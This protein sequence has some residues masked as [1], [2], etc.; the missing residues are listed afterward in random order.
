VIEYEDEFGRARTGRRSEVPAHLLPPAAR[1]G[2]AGD[3]DEPLVEYTDEFG[4]T[5]TVPRSEV[6]REFLRKTDE[7]VAE[8]EWAF[9]L[10]PL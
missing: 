7:P 4:R 6:P 10:Y 3:A 8:D 5:R 9:L 2:G 1:A